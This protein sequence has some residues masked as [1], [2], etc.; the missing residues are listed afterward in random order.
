MVEG[1]L[2]GRRRRTRCPARAPRRSGQSPLARA[3]AASS[4][5]CP[6]LPVA[7][8]STAP[9][10]TGV[11]A[12]IW[13]LAPAG[14]PEREPPLV[15]AGI[16]LDAGQLAQPLEAARPGTISATSTMMRSLTTSERRRTSPAMTALCHAGQA[17]QRGPKPFSLVGGM[18]GEPE[19]AGLAQECD[20][21]ED[22]L[23]GPGAEPGQLGQAAVVAR[24]PRARA[25]SRSRAPRGSGGSWRRRDPRSRASRPA[26][27]GSARAAPRA[28]W[29][30]RSRPAR[31]RSGE[32]PARR[33]S[34]RPACRLPATAEGRPGK[35][36][37]ARA[38]VRK[39]RIRNGFSPFSSRKAA[40]CSSTCATAFLSM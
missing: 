15:L 29:R 14:K 23:R 20:G 1:V 11:V 13:A 28:C 21:L 26:R 27:A 6:S 10:L 22:V 18:M 34:P 17:L 33:P 2:I 38:A 40:I 32:W 8:T 39:A 25:R 16:L 31:S 19:G 3:C 24:R 12:T 35:P 30:G 5:R 4:R 9:A 7:C 37:R 36:T